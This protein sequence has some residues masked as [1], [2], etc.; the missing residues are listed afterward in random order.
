MIGPNGILP[1]ASRS[2]EQMIQDDEQQQLQEMAGTT[3]IASKEKIAAAIEQAIHAKQ[4]RDYMLV[5]ETSELRAQEQ[6]VDAAPSYDPRVAPSA[7]IFMWFWVCLGAIFLLG[8]HD[9]KLGN[10]AKPLAF[11]PSDLSWRRL[12][13]AD[14]YGSIRYAFRALIALTLGIIVASIA[15]LNAVPIFLPGATWSRGSI[16]LPCYYWRLHQSY[17]QGC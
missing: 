1:I 2:T 17:P 6:V 9:I 13:R 10:W 14:C 11:G 12:S 5:V 15:A 7:L 3:N 4:P 8:M 16:S